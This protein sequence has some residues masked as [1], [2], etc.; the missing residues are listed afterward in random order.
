MLQ[1]NRDV[2]FWDRIARK[3]AAHRIKDMPGY[4]RTVERTRQLLEGADTV[5]EI[6]CGTGTTALRLAPSVGRIVAT[7]V[8]GE[9]I[10]IAREKAV[11]DGCHNAEF[12]TA[13]AESG[14]GSAGAYDGVLAFNVLH[15][16]V[17][18]ASALACIHGVV[19]PGGLFISKTPCLSEM[20]P[21]IRLAVPM[22]Q[23]VGKAPSVSFLSAADLEA[24]IER[25]G[26]SIVERDRHGSGRKDPRI[27]IVARKLPA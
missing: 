13:S 1:A 15:L 9:M 8:S 18:R 4:E 7:D 2:R 12:I 23:M 26:F 10:A 25:A 14:P 21:L 22:A 24:D 11:V 3:Y 16:I 5:L 27:F 20:N 6:G 17:D 19:R